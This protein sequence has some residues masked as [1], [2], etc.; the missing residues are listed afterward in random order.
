M[1]NGY[2]QN[3]DSYHRHSRNE[4]GNGIMCNFANSPGKLK[5]GAEKNIQDNI[6]S[7]ID[8]VPGCHIIICKCK[9]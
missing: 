6:Q 9:K 4:T 1:K 2:Q 5:E 7:Q 3:I 8:P